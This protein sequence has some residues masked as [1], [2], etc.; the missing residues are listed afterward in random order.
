[1]KST[2]KSAYVWGEEFESIDFAIHSYLQTVD[3]GQDANFNGQFKLN[4]LSIIIVAILGLHL[5]TQVERFRSRKQ[6]QLC[7]TKV[8]CVLFRSRHY[9]K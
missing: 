7:L 1:M 4:F 8:L 5:T 3:E 6:K 2:S 9:I